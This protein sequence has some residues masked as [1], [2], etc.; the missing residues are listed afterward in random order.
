MRWRAGVGRRD[1]LAVG[2]VR[3]FD[4]MLLARQL[5]CRSRGSLDAVRR[6]EPRPTGAAGY[7]QTEMEVRGSS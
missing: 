3:A 2:R 7:Q 5:G 4:N 1:T 6:G